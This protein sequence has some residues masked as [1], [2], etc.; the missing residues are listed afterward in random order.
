MTSGT[1]GKAVGSRPSSSSGFSLPANRSTSGS[2]SCSAASAEPTKASLAMPLQEA[3]LSPGSVGNDRSTRSS[4]AKTED[5]LRVVG[6]QL[7]R[8]RRIP[9]ELDFDVLDSRNGRRRIVD[10]LLD[11]R[12]GRTAHRGQAVY[13]LDLR[14]VDLDVVEQPQLDDVHAELRVLD[15]AQ[16]LGD[17]LFR[18][19][20][21]SLAAWPCLAPG[22]KTQHG[23]HR[24]GPPEPGLARR[25][26]HVREENAR[27][28]A[29]R[30]GSWTL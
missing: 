11:H 17:V 2:T 14:A 7:R 27:I 1:V 8:P 23:D 13:D 19:H 22:G 4:L 25:E 3:G 5:E 29:R 21:P 18:R 10:A 24:P 15:P 20:D 28:R 9:R 16:C 6:H 26:A 30:G 12:P